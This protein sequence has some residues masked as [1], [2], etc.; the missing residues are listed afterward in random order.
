MH[1]DQPQSFWESVLWIDGTKLELF[2][3]SHQLYVHRC[4]NE[5]YK[6]KNTSVKRGGGASLFWGCF[7]TS[8]TGCLE[9][10][11]GT[12]KSQDCQCI[13]GRNV[14]ARVRQLGLSRRP[15]VL[16]HDNDPKHRAGNNQEQINSDVA[17][18]ELHPIGP[19]WKELKIMQSGEDTLQT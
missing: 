1:V 10:V 15:R 6:E 14:Q 19:L 7:V 18:Y 12:M 9:S 11:H 5:A 2:G 16:Q 4:K 3:K 13:L 17:F 8:G